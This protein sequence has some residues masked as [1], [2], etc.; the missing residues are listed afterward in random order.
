LFNYKINYSLIFLELE[1][2]ATAAY[3]TNR[4]YYN[5]PPAIIIIAAT[6]I[7]KTTH[8]LIPPFC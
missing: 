8:E 2:A 3:D 1:A 4:N 5:Y 7:I 6:V